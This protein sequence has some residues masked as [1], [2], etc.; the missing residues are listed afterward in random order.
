MFGFGNPKQPTKSELYAS[1]IVGMDI[2]DEQA[3]QDAELA[4]YRA[5]TEEMRRRN[6]AEIA[7]MRRHP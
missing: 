6:D 3:Q 7:R 5:E 1:H 2:M 4:A